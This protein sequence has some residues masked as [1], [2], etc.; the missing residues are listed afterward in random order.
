ME[1]L[2]ITVT[3]DS[4]IQ[5]DKLASKLTSDDGAWTCSVCG[6]RGFWYGGPHCL[7]GISYEESYDTETRKV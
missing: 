1:A 5:Q 3:E 2:K 6:Y 7:K 4:L